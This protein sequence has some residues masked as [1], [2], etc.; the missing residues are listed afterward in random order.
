MCFN[1]NIIDENMYV[2]L[3]KSYLCIKFDIVF[4]IAY[5]VLFREILVPSPKTKPVLTCRPISRRNFIISQ[6]ENDERYFK[7]TFSL[8]LALGYSTRTL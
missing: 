8:F 4:K 7:A 2:E 3:H 6:K 1:V 5:D